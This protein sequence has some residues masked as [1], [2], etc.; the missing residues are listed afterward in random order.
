MPPSPAPDDARSPAPSSWRT[1]RPLG[2]AAGPD[3]GV[4][5]SW[6]RWL[7]LGRRTHRW[8]W[9]AWT[10]HRLQLSDPSVSANH[11]LLIDLG[12][13]TLVVDL[14]S[15]NGTVVLSPA[16]PTSAPRPGH[17]DDAVGALRRGKRTWIAM[18]SHQSLIGLGAS[19]LDL[20]GAVGPA[21]KA[22]EL[23][24]SQRAAQ[25]WLLEGRPQRW[26]AGEERESSARADLTFL[27]VATELLSSG[28]GDEP[29]PRAVLAGRSGIVVLAPQAPTSPAWLEHVESEGTLVRASCDTRHHLARLV[30]D[31]CSRHEPLTIVSEDATALAYPELLANASA[32]VCIGPVEASHVQELLGIEASIADGQAAVRVDGH[33]YRMVVPLAARESVSQSPARFA[34]ASEA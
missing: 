16:R 28:S 17:G 9:R 19:V 18:A 3:A 10:A 20:S 14:G 15:A 2:V 32:I 34:P 27:G 12:K 29:L 21:A 33:V 31:A 30:K 7:V 26:S 25:R 6:S 22:E 5:W 13:A 4:T 11:A 24:P 23:H 1:L 8:R